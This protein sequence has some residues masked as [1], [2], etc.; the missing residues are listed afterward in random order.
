MNPGRLKFPFSYGAGLPAQTLK[1]PGY[2]ACHKPGSHQ[3]Q[4]S[5]KTGNGSKKPSRVGQ[6]GFC[7]RY[8]HISHQIFSPYITGALCLIEPEH[9]LPLSHSSRDIRPF[10]FLKHP[11][12]NHLTAR[13]ADFL[14]FPFLLP[15]P[16]KGKLQP[17]I[18]GN[19]T[20]FRASLSYILPDLAQKFP[21]IH[22]L[23][24]P[25]QSFVPIPRIHLLRHGLDG[26]HQ[27]F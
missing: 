2:A 3:G 24:I 8:L 17:G 15:L 4:K 11:A 26:F 10:I 23:L 6:K 1:L 27:M 25:G 7:V 18:K 9:V 22:L 21:G 5:Q 13:P 20:G 16:G 12:G 19:K 14:S